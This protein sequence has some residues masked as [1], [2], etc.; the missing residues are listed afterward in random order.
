[1]PFGSGQTISGTDR[2]R[3]SGLSPCRP[4]RVRDPCSLYACK[5]MN[6]DLKLVTH[7]HAQSLY[8]AFIV[9]TTFR[10]ISRNKFSPIEAKVVHVN[11]A[12]LA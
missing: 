4:L 3:A 12:I 7:K 5:K 9:N 11:T 1:M 8:L 6:S 2:V 10:F